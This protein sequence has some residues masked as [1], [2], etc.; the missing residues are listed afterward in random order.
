MRAAMLRPDQRGFEGNQNQWA[1][2]TKNDKQ[3]GCVRF[4]CS[5]MALSTRAG[6]T[7]IERRSGGGRRRVSRRSGRWGRKCG[8]H[9]SAASKAILGNLYFHIVFV[10]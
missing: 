3:F 1:D 4:L 8:R 2:R 6:M 7:Q 9:R 10:V 5:G